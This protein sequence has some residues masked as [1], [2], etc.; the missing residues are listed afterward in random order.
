MAAEGTSSLP[1]VCH[2]SLSGQCCLTAYG[3]LRTRGF[4]FQKKSMFVLKFKGNQLFCRVDTAYL[5]ATNDLWTEQKQSHVCLEWGIHLRR[6][7][8]PESTHSRAPYKVDFIKGRKSMCHSRSPR[9]PPPLRMPLP[10]SKKSHQPLGFRSAT[11]RNPGT[12]PGGF[13]KWI[14]QLPARKSLTCH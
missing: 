6:S 1:K 13:S 14:Q 9:R 11:I 10:K 3:T 7:L 2:L 4:C 5:P 12:S 8:S